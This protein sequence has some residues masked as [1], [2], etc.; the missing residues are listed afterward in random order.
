MVLLGDEVGGNLDM[1]GNGHLVGEK[2]LCEKVCIAQRKSK[3]RVKYFTVIGLKNLLGE[4]I[5]CIVIIE[6][7]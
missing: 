6:G 7:K 2:F 5:C 3:R 1:N 4:T